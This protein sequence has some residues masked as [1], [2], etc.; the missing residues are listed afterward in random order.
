MN[1]KIK[2]VRKLENSFLIVLGRISIPVQSDLQNDTK[3]FFHRGETYKITQEPKK[4]SDFGQTR[5]LNLITS[6][7]NI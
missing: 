2:Q 5:M 7:P 6:K 4:K 1:E 3:Q